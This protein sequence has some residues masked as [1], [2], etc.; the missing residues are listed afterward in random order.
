MTIKDYIVNDRLKDIAKGRY[1][2][3]RVKDIIHSVCQ[4]VSQD[5]E[6]AVFEYCALMFL[7]ELHY[8]FGFGKK[9]L[10]RFIG[11]FSEKA[12]AFDAGAYDIE[13]MRNAL[14]EDAGIEIT[15]VWG[16]ECKD[17]QS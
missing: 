10:E 1:S 5:V 13:D 6:R 12:L 4:S 16:S 7:Q 15:M 2:A 8:E 17:S 9:R 3:D 11:D 14:K